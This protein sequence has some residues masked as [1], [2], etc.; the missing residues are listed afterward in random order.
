M[1]R[2]ARLRSLQTFEQGQKQTS[3][4]STHPGI[5]RARPGARPHAHRA[6]P[7]QTCAPARAHA[8]KASRGFNRMPPLALNLTGAP[9]H[10]RLLCA[11][12]ASG[13]PRTDHRRPAI[14]AIPHPVRPSRESPRVS[15]KLLEPGFELYLNRDT[16]SASPDFTRSPAYVDRAPR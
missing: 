5:T 11:R 15:V 12:R 1:A 4:C 14:L 8:Y 6:A 10:Q 16:E 9:H 2:F 13:H 7:S 3:T